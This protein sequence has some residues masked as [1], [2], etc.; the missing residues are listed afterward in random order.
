MR[1]E[2]RE[3]TE[4]GGICYP[5]TENSRKAPVAQVREKGRAPTVRLRPRPQ[6]DYGSRSGSRCG[7]KQPT[8]RSKRG[9]GFSVGVAVVQMKSGMDLR[10]PSTGFDRSTVADDPE[11]YASPFFFLSL[12]AV[13]CRN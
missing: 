10:S 5:S 8:D 12:T 4:N 13:E 9:R 6:R 2:G 11:F 7:A 3:G 1:T